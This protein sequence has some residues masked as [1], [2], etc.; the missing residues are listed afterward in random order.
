MAGERERSR[1]R[2]RGRARVGCE[3]ARR[4]VDLSVALLLIVVLAP[5]L[6]AIGAAIRLTDG[7]PALFRQERVGRHQHPFVMYKFRTMRPGSDSDRH[8]AYVTQQLTGASPAHGGQEGVYKLSRDPRV[9]RV[10]AALR[11]T[12]L[13]ELP[14]LFNVVE[15]SMSLVGPR[16]ALP[17][18]VPLYQP[19]HLRRFDVKPGITGLWQVR[20]RSTVPLREALDMDVE[21]VQ[22]RG[23]WLDVRILARTVVV[24]LHGFG[25]R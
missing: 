19:R 14:Q 22:N 12:S 6:L 10:G 20:G 11:R 25:A 4:V 17:Y 5:V 8:R 23:A 15:G 3:R 13:D 2:A 24:V 1:G 9:T 18:E 16:P 21:Y 7:G